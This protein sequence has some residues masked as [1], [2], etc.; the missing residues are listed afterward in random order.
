MAPK[1]KSDQ[2]T[3]MPA[4]KGQRELKLDELD[5]VVGGAGSTDAV[6][7]SDRIGPQQVQHKHLAGVKYE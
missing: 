5:N 4:D 1:S 2:R 3:K 6:V 7:Q